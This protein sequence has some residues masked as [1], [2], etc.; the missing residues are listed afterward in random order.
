MNI[1]APVNSSLSSPKLPVMVWHLLPREKLKSCPFYK[2]WIYGGSWDSGEGALYDGTSLV[3]TGNVIFVSFNYRLGPFGFLAH[4][5]LGAQTN[6]SYGLFGLQDQTM[7][8]QWVKS[9]SASFGG[10]PTQV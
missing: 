8:L 1:I 3:Q 2:V 7:A 6:S 9:N 4:P 5:A 10:D